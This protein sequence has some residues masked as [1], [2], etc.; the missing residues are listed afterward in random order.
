MTQLHIL[1]SHP[2]AAI[3]QEIYQSLDAAG[4]PVEC[5]PDLQQKRVDIHQLKYALLIVD[6][7][8]PWS[9][10]SSICERFKNASF[11]VPTILLSAKATIRRA[12]EM[13]Q[14]GACDFL[15]TPVNTDILLASVAKV[16]SNPKDQHCR[17]CDDADSHSLIT[18][19][20]RM[21]QLLAV[22]KRV[23]NSTATILIQGESGTGKE[24]L[25][26]FIHHHSERS[27]QPFVAMNCA[28]L[29]ENLAESEL[30]GYTKGAFTGAVKTRMGK[31]EQAHTGTLLLD[32]VSE[33]P[34]TLQAKL[35]RVLQEKEIDPLGGHGPIRIDVRCIA[36]S[37]Q[38]LAMMVQQGRFRQDLYYRLRVLPL[39]LPPLRDRKEDIPELVRYFVRKYSPADQ[40]LPKFDQAAM[41]YLHG[42]DWPGNVRELENTVER[43]L[44][45]HEGPVIHQDAL[46]VDQDLNTEPSEQ[47]DS[48]VGMTV[49]ELE[50]KLIGQTLSHLNHNRTQAAKMLGISIRTLRNKLREYQHKE[51][52]PNSDASPL[53]ELRQNT[54]F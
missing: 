50:K 48:M 25:A 36:T 52:S 37:N 6:E 4:Y 49:K 20:E 16:L 13:I 41:E 44:L 1:I 30:F 2:N 47:H 5:C 21:H 8:S 23:A 33:M 19:A 45:I 27:R 29:P 35:L 14:S 24:V 3:A 15:A 7:S 10:G 51:E 17:Q 39:T 46:L 43:A 11:P 54:P 40:P 28:A 32:E 42:W 53:S 18:K 22:A 26:R 9:N 34:F 38:D 31:F 12:V